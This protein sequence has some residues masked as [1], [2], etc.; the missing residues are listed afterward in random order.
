VSAYVRA[1]VR[2]VVR[3]ETASVAVSGVMIGIGPTSW[4][5]HRVLWRIG[6]DITRTQSHARA[7]KMDCVSACVHARM[8]AG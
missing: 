7:L 8:D 1:C 2:M 6:H 3:E 5:E 4:A